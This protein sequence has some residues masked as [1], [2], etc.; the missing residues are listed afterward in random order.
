LEEIEEEKQREDTER[1]GDAWLPD[2]PHTVEASYN[3]NKGEYT[4]TDDDFKIWVM[5]P[6]IM[7]YLTT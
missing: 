2:D 3:E 4:K 1:N 7:M 6:R 5:I